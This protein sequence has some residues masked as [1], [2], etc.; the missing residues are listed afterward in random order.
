MIDEKGCNCSICA[1]LSS[2]PQSQRQFFLSQIRASRFSKYGMKFTMQDKL[3]ALGL[4]CKSPSA[5]R[6]MGNTFHLPSERTLQSNIGNLNIGCGFKWDYMEALRKRVDSMHDKEKCC[7]VT[8]DGMA[9]KSKLQ[10]SECQDIIS[11]FVNLD[12]FGD[13]SAEIAKQALQFMVRG[14][15]SRWKQ[16]IGHFFGGNCVKAETLQ[17]MILKAVSS[18]EEI[19]LSVMAIVCDQ[20]ASHQVL[21][22]ILGSTLNKPWFMSE[23]N[24]KVYVL[25]DVPHLIKNLRNNLLNYDIVTETG[26][27]IASFGVIRKLYD[28]EKVS[29]LLL[30]PK[31]TDG[32]VNLKPFKKM[33][34]SLATQVLSHS[35]SSAIRTYVRFSKLPESSLSMASFVETIDNIF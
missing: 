16:P 4:Y 2:L 29:C 30:C 15:S 5:Y 19:G 27:I 8:F 18:L 3:L 10:Y 35:V 11:G 31:L 20:E 26:D 7:I 14:I 28:L 17:R 22:N 1:D 6:F 21:Y 33:K 12:E 23:K 32:H 34:V 25:Y 9:L 13:S 24:N